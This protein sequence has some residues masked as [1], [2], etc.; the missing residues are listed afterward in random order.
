MAWASTPCRAPGLCVR[1]R[2]A[3]G[4]LHGRGTCQGQEILVGGGR[5]VGWGDLPSCGQTSRGT[6]NNTV[7]L[8]PSR[9][10]VKR[11]TGHNTGTHAP[12]KQ[13]PR[14]GMQAQTSHGTHTGRGGTSATHRCREGA[15][16]A[17]GLWL[18]R[19]FS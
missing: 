6:P 15:G 7:R 8:K 1:E 11:R 16:E 9:A 12:G 13:L 17:G 10:P 5:W 14:L 3:R 2:R 4:C 18:Q 19:P